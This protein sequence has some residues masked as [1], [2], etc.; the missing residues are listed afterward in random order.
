MRNANPRRAANIRGYT[1]VELLIV[2]AIIGVLA[3]LGVAGF[4]RY[5]RSAATSEATAV[6]SGIRSAEENYKAETLQYLGC[7]GCNSATG[8]LQPTGTLATVY[9]QT[10]GPTKA[11]WAWRNPGHAD[12]ACWRMLN[13]TT[14]GAVLFA[15]SVVAG[16][17]GTAVGSP[18]PAGYGLTDPGWPNP[19]VD[20]WYVVQATGD[21]N[22]DSHRSYFASSSFSGEVFAKDETE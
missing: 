5:V 3:A 15:Y 14:D 4:Q 10:A 22:G 8:C 6:I 20:P 21:Q 12:Y 7:S 1:L 18:G 17:A 9:P 13:V 19:P 16:A 2:V 11:K